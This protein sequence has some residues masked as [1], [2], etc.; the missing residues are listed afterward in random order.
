MRIGALAH[1]S[2]VSERLLR[3]YEQQGLLAPSRSGNGYR[4]YTEDDLATV[5]RIRA[6]L[7]SGLSTTLIAK[8]L[9]CLAG[10]PD[11]LAPTC[12]VLVAD[13]RAERARLDTQM[14]ALAT[15]ATLLDEVLS[16]EVGP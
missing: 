2:G 16:R 6:L 4:E 5:A 15:S 1:R 12:P 3:Y 11:R 9:P 14:A 10:T 8:A 13:L 7:A